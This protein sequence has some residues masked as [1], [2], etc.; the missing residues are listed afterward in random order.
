MFYTVSKVYKNKE[1]TILSFS[2]S[3]IKKLGTNFVTVV[4]GNVSTKVHQLEFQ[5]Y[6][7]HLT[8]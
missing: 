8:L 7:T 2:F 1:T 6:S 3:N 4:K 5:L